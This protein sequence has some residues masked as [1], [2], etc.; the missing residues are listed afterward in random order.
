M[1]QTVEVVYSSNVCDKDRLLMS[2]F[3]EVWMC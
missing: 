2:Y 1:L 3:F